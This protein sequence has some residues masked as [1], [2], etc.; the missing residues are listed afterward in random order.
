[1]LAARVVPMRLGWQDG[2]L[3]ARAVPL[4]KALLFIWCEIISYCDS[5]ANR[6]N[7]Q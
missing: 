4:T 6:L 3:A 2:A 7:Q 1:M 5:C